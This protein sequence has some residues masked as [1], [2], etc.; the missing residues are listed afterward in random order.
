M[1]HDVHLTYHVQE[2]LVALLMCEATCCYA[3]S[4]CG[5]I[6]FEYLSESHSARANKLRI[7]HTVPSLFHN[8]FYIFRARV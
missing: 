7:L 6:D 2:I 4:I 8:L 5:T 1:S 3:S